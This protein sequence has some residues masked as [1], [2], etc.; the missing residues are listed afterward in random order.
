MVECNCVIKKKQSLLLWPHWYNIAKL[1]YILVAIVTHVLTS[2]PS[3]QDHKPAVTL[4]GADDDCYWWKL[5]YEITR[6]AHHRLRSLLL[7]PSSIH[8]PND[9]DLVVSSMA[10][11]I[12]IKLS[13]SACSTSVLSTGS[14][15]VIVAFEA[16]HSA[17]SLP[18][19]Y[20]CEYN[21]T[22]YTFHREKYRGWKREFILCNFW[23][24][25]GSIYTCVYW[26]FKIWSGEMSVEIF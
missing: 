20:T 13:L 9:R 7:V 14:V 21:V 26:I 10:F 19:T 17:L 4:N 2:L 3:G 22:T 11:S 18:R 12:L 8:H 25:N 15:P 1:K 24:W 5:N 23:S 6:C 16:R